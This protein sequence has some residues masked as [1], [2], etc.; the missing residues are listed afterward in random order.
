MKTADALKTARVEGGR[1][2]CAKCGGMINEK[3]A[4]HR[5]KV[6]SEAPPS[7]AKGKANAAD[8]GSVPSPA[9]AAPPT[10]APGE[11]TPEKKAYDVD[12]AI[13]EV[14]GEK[15]RDKEEKAV[16]REERDAKIKRDARRKKKVI[17]TDVYP[18][19][20]REVWKHFHRMEAAFV[21]WIAGTRGTPEELKLKG[22]DEEEILADLANAAFPLDIDIKIAYFIL[23]ATIFGG[24]IVTHLDTLA[25]RV[26]GFMRKRDERKTQKAKAQADLE[27]AKAAL[28]KRQ[29]AN[30]EQAAPATGEKGTPDASARPAPPPAPSPAPAP[31]AQAPGPAPEVR[32]SSG[33]PKPKA[34]EPAADKPVDAEFVMIPKADTIAPPKEGDA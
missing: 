3:Y 18:K 4:T 19:G 33:F 28:A 8:D 27:A 13:D 17:L 2:F 6:S 31:V 12:G 15:T 7:P 34:P 9:P 24:H 26:S 25:A 21:N 1:K 29:E 22:T 14:L 30:A 32:P 5:C 23:Q 20:G 10:T 16:A 11:G